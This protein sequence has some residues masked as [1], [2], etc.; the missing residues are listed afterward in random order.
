MESQ[1]RNMVLPKGWVQVFVEK[2]DLEAAFKGL[3]SCMHFH[4]D[5]M[6]GRVRSL[7]MRVNEAEAYFLIALEG[8]NRAPRTAK[9]IIRQ[10]V[11]H[12]YWLEN[13]L[14]QEPSNV[15]ED[16]PPLDHP[17]FPEDLKQAHPELQV[18]EHMHLSAEGFLRLHAGDYEAAA[19]L[20]T[21]LVG[22]L[23]EDVGGKL[24]FAYV[25]LAAAT[26]NMGK[27]EEAARHFENAGL[28]IQV[29]GS[30]L[31]KLRVA[32]NLYAIYRCLGPREAAADWRHFVD[33]I[34]CPQAT[35]DALLTRTKVVVERWARSEKLLLV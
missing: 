18:V 3:S 1:R 12:T 21:D 11:L 25:G 7:Q 15:A 33:R 4:A 24:A 17:A 29:G 35:K 23:R 22:K 5:T 6:R 28:S 2:A 19:S 20:Y 27:P 9:N 8:S 13:R 10:V 32:A 34:E 30:T 14:L 26:Y 31:D 16:L